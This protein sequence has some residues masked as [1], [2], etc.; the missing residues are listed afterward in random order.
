LIEEALTQAISPAAID[1]LFAQTPGQLAR[2]ATFHQV[3]GFMLLLRR[4]VT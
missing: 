4:T 3:F 1:A 2:P